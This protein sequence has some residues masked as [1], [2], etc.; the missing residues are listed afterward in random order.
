MEIE[1]ALE[2]HM[3]VAGNTSS[4]DVLN[5][6]IVDWIPRDLFNQSKSELLS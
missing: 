5:P 6:G 1:T 4:S 3:A 2:M